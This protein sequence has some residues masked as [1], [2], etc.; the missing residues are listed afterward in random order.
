MANSIS[1][2]QS[3]THPPPY[4]SR[5]LNRNSLQTAPRNKQGRPQ[6][7]SLRPVCGRTTHNGMKG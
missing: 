5:P 7:Q 2:T 6:T 4:R 3:I 1:P